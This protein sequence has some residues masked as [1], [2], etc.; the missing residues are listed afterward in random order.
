MGGHQ[1]RVVPSG[2]SVH[3]RQYQHNLFAETWP[4]GYGFFI[5]PDVALHPTVMTPR[6]A[7]PW[8]L[9]Q[10][11]DVLGIHEARYDKFAL[12]MIFPERNDQIDQIF[13]E[14]I[15]KKMTRNLF[16]L[17]GELADEIKQNVDEA[18]GED[19][20]NW[21]DANVWQTVDKTVFTALTHVLVGQSVCREPTFRDDVAGFT[22]AFGISSIV[23][24]R[25][26]PKFLKPI[27]GWLLSSVT[28][29]RQRKLL[30][31]W[32]DPLV[33]KRFANIAKSLQ[34]PKLDYHA[35]QDLITWA[36]ETLLKTGKVVRC[37]PSDLSRR[38][39]LMIPAAFPAV[40]SATT[41][42]LYDLLSTDPE[43][44]V[45]EVLHNEIASALE[46]CAQ[47]W[48][49]PALLSRLGYLESAIR[50]SFRCN[51]VS[52]I[53][54]ERKVLAR[55]GIDLPSGDHLPFGTI[56]G[57]PTIGVHTDDE[58]YK[59][60]I[61]YDPFRFRKRTLGE[62]VDGQR[63]AA[64]LVSSTVVNV[65]DA[66]LNF[67]TGKGACPGRWLASH[68]IKISIA[69]LLHNYEME[70]YARRPM[71]T[72]LFGNNMPNRSATMRVRR[73]KI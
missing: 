62:N 72:V 56:L 40:K 1:E 18:L 30:K 59:N 47:G 71:N 33:E 39:A 64:P 29:W 16:K 54:A 25:I 11:Q 17:Q 26:L 37:S 63:P 41:N 13:L 57:V 3:S 5:K 34:D 51:P 73:R 45:L 15:H 32:F 67:G 65:S 49:D 35:P 19:T 2:Q 28:L 6:S 58:I 70:H 55:G 42:A 27:F 38:L 46:S 48:A 44:G 21:V 31:T 23:V 69:Y 20:E 43:S 50:E 68:V 61:Q 60:G 14:V 9:D 36:T 22:K 24:G 10:S 12:D 52:L 66:Y 8:V 4:S 7:I 53:V